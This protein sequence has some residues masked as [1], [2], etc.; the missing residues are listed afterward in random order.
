VKNVEFT[1]PQKRVFSL[2][3]TSLAVN[4][5][6]LEDVKH[7][8]KG[9]IFVSNSNVKQHTVSMMASQFNRL[10]GKFDGGALFLENVKTDINDC[11]FDSNK[12][13]EQ[14]GGA[15][16]FSCFDVK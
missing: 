10:E 15:I 3:D 5:F 16:Y 1:G 12:S 13:S 11:T 7:T 14:S 8:S 9:A 4:S 6:K 2:T